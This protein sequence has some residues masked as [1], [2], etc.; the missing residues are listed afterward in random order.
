MIARDASR[1]VRE[2]GSSVISKRSS[3]GV[4]FVSG[5]TKECLND[6]RVCFI[7]IYF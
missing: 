3:S 2:S 1:D 4:G 5:T 7:F 6:F